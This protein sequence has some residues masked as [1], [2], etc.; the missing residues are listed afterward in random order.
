LLDKLATLVSERISKS[1][2]AVGRGLDLSP[3]T[4]ELV[5][6]S[7][8]PPIEFNNLVKKNDD[9]DKFGKYNSFFFKNNSCYDFL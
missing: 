5:N 6:D 8:P 7:Q 3:P 9:N 4:A 1:S 2:Q